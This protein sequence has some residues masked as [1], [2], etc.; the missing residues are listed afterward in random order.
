MAADGWGMGTLCPGGWNAEPWKDAAFYTC[1]FASG[2]DING[3]ELGVG[4]VIKTR[5]GL[6]SKFAIGSCHIQNTLLPEVKECV[7]HSNGHQGEP[8]LY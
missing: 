1:D 4:L 3:M 5:G 7:I 8:L 2:I 6:L